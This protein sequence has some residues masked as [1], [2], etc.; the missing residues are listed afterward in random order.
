MFT[1]YTKNAHRE[2]TSARGQ[3]VKVQKL[4]HIKLPVTVGGSLLRAHANFSAGDTQSGALS[5][6]RRRQEQVGANWVAVPP[7]QPD[8]ARHRWLTAELAAPRQSGSLGLLEILCF[9]GFANQQEFQLSYP[10]ASNFQI[11]VD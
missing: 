7:P 11:Y 1:A 3:V 5:K 4:D 10:M 8:G 6:N 9:S 2:R